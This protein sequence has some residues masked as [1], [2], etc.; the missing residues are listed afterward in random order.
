[1]RRFREISQLENLECVHYLYFQDVLRAA[2]IRPGVLP[3]SPSL[4]VSDQACLTAGLRTLNTAE[5]A[6]QSMDL[7]AALGTD[8]FAAGR[9]SPAAQIDRHCQAA[10]ARPADYLEDAI[11]FKPFPILLATLLA[12]QVLE[13]GSVVT[14]ALLHVED[15]KGLAVPAHDPQSFRER[16]S[17]CVIRIQG[18][19]SLHPGA[20][21]ALLDPAVEA[22]SLQAVAVLARFA[23]SFG[24]GEGGLLLDFEAVEACEA[25]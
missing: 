16:R 6:P 20:I 7:L 3:R 2:E 19:E 1:M 21:D 23:F 8:V 24:G 18:G 25:V 5:R 13:L 17:A 11:G 10:A 14:T 22:A 4:F 9:T 15:P 12:W